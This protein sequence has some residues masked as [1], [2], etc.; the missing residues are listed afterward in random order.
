MTVKK[1]KTQREG[2]RAPGLSAGYAEAVL[3]N[4]LDFVTQAD[5]Y[6]Y[7]PGDWTIHDDLLVRALAIK[8]NRSACKVII[9]CDLY[10][11][12][13]KFCQTIRDLINDGSSPGGSTGGLFNDPFWFTGENF[14]TIRSDE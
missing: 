6:G 7:K 12:D 4:G 10:G 3:T 2:E 9:T 11:L 14:G 1:G 8:S 5:E 13:Y